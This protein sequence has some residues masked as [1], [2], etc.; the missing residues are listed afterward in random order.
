[1]S[2][3]SSDLKHLAVLVIDISDYRGGPGPTV[4]STIERASRVAA[5]GT[6]T[7]SIAHEVKNPLAAI[8]VNAGACRRWLR[9]PVPD[10]AEA[11]DAIASVMNDAVRAQEVVDRTLSF[12]K[13]TPSKAVELDIT[14]V[15]RD[16]ILLTMWDVQRYDV[17]VEFLPDSQLPTVFADLIRVQQILMNLIL[18]AVQ[19]M[20]NVQRGRRIIIRVHDD[21]DMVLVEV[22]D[23]GTGIASEQLDRIFEPFYSTKNTGIGMGLAVSRACV[24]A[25]GGRIWVKTVLGAGT[26]FYFTVPVHVS[27]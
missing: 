24:E 18:N 19:A 26:S 3:H 27:N 17:T 16:T 1:L 20:L 13:P 7:A 15:I 5:M 8:V 12:L 6:L 9:L 4:Q 25:N 2:R 21:K 10:L 23:M 14:S 22:A 11:E